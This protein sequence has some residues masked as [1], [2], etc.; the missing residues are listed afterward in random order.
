MKKNKRLYPPLYD[1]SYLHLTDMRKV[2]SKFA[3]TASGVV[4]DYGAGSKPYQS[5][6]PSTVR[7]R[8]A[9]FFVSDSDDLL[10]KDKTRLP[11]EDAC[12]DWVVSFQVLEHVEDPLVFLQECRRALRPRGTLLL[13]THGIWPY[14]TG[15]NCG[16]FHRWTGDGLALL[17]Q[18]AGFANLEIEAA[19]T[20]WRAILQQI[21][22]IKDPARLFQDSA[23]LS[24]P[25]LRKQVRRLFNLAINVFAEAVDPIWRNYNAR[26]DIIPIAYI[27]KATA[28]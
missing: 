19:T 4:I 18:K 5:L 8:G 15:E 11:V 24:Q 22:A 20:G 23:R 25:W 9:D 10:I 21:L 3:P 28:A 27:V 13:S 7:Y 17:I 6:F 1:A 14:H 12:A 2:I 16:D 26:T